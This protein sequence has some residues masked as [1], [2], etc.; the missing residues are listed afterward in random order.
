MTAMTVL[1]SGSEETAGAARIQ[2]SAALTD[3][4]Q[5]RTVSAAHLE[6]GRAVRVADTCPSRAATSV[7]ASGGPSASTSRRS[8]ACRTTGR[9]PRAARGRKPSRPTPVKATPRRVGI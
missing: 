7:G 2:I 8:A 5:D 6:D 4:V 3:L 9:R 1:H